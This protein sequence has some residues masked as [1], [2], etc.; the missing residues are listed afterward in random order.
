[1]SE[2]FDF[3]AEYDRL[4]AEMYEPK[5]DAPETTD[6]PGTYEEWLTFTGRPSPE[7]MN[8]RLC[9]RRVADVEVHQAPRKEEFVR[10]V[11][12]HFDPMYDDDAY[13]PGQTEPVSIG[14]YLFWTFVGFVAALFL[15]QI[16]YQAG[17]NA[18][19]TTNL[20]LR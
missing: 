14:A 8:D 1:M 7:A 17:L 2:P 16:G 18:A 13:I 11:R 5:P 19:E 15:L 6:L 4:R 10:L 3:N 12:A 9:L 20:V